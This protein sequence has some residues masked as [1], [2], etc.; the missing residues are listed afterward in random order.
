MIKCGIPGLEPFIGKKVNQ[1]TIQIAKHQGSYARGI[2]RQ[3][4]VYFNP[5]GTI[6]NFS[7]EMKDP[8]AVIEALTEMIES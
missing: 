2:L 7:G 5:D 8:D 6:T 3:V 1:E 4:S